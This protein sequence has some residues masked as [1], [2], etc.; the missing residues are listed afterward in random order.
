MNNTTI[1]ERIIQSVCELQEMPPLDDPETLVVS[2]NDL[3]TIIENRLS[4]AIQIE[5]SAKLDLLEALRAILHTY[6]D[7]G[8]PLSVAFKMANSAISKATS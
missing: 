8:V 3:R 1:A 2:V 5:T 6:D 7:G 4:V